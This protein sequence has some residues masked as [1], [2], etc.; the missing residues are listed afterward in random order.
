MLQHM[1]GG[2]WGFVIRRVLEAGTRLIPIMALL[3]IPVILGAH[4][5]L[6]QAVAGETMRREA[7]AIRHI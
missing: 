1:T 7:A 4:S 6:T 2:G 5:I 3:F